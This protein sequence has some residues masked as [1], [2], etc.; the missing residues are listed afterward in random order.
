MQPTGQAGSIASALPRLAQWHDRVTIAGF[1][2]ATLLIGVIAA[3]FCYEVVVRYFF[4]APTSWTYAVGSY[5]LCAAIFL[6][7]PDLTRRNAHISVNLIFEHLSPKR[8]R[9]LAVFIGLLA[10]AA[11]FVAA[12]ITGSESLRQFDDDISTITSFP[13]PKW[14][15][16]VF[17]PY[18]F[19]SSAIY[20]LRNLGQATGYSLP[21][22]GAGT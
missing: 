13:I 22:E 8:T 10:A 21:I 7:I 5:A 3:S 19:F 17:I 16:S 6:A 9:T 20:F 18:G 4:G 12:W 2:A 15:V 1:A 11:C 14:W